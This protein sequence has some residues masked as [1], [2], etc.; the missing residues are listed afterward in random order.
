MNISEWTTTNKSKNDLV[1]VFQIAL[2][3][4]YCKILDDPNLLNELRKY[5]ADI[6][7]KT[8]TIT[9]NGYKCHDDMV[10]STM[11]AY[12]AYKKGLGKMNISFA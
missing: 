7:V 9:Y 2:E 10:I 5:Q 8:K 3:N 12:W 11:L 6:N 1:S 4:G